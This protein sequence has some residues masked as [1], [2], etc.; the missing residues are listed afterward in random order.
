MVINA[1]KISI[2][3]KRYD[4]KKKKRNNRKTLLNKINL[5]KPNFILKKSILKIINS[6]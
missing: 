5:F 2:Y 3:Y 4:W 1:I 6:F